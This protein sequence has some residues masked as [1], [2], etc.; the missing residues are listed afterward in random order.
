MTESLRASLERIPGLVPIAVNLQAAGIAWGDIGQF[1][2]RQ[3]LYEWGLQAFDESVGIKD[4][5]RT[6][7]AVLAED[8]LVPDALVP[9]GFLFHMSRC[10][11]TVLSKALAHGDGNLVISEPDPLNQLLFFLTD[12]NLA[13]QLEAPERIG[14]LRNMILALGR[15]RQLE[16]DR[17]YLKFSSWNVLLVETI[18][19]TFPGVPSVFVY[20]NPEE[21]MV[22][23]DKR[24]TGFAQ[25]KPHVIAK[26]MSGC[27]RA[28]LDQMSNEQYVAAVLA[29]MIKS[30]LDAP[31]MHFLNYTAV[32]VESFPRLLAH[33]GYIPDTAS[34]R[35]MSEQFD[36]DAK[37]R[38]DRSKFGEDGAEKRAA[39]TASIRDACDQ[40]LSDPFEI[41]QKSERNLVA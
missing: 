35:A 12:N 22:S 15:R 5:I 4:V 8:D 34:L 24:P 32:G 16:N 27:N 36:Y 18:L 7:L 30:A 26:S 6:P 29:R 10:G 20:R 33:F 28:T 11:S 2:L 13:L 17:Y 21:V 40:W 3:A 31:T 25:A 19:R 37:S 14:M 9:S 1:Q 41:L 23:I 39:V 38:E